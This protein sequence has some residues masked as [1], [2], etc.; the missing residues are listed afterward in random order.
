M[1]NR[2]QHAGKRVIDECLGTSRGRRACLT[3]VLRNPGKMPLTWD[4]FPV[5]CWCGD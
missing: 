4:L 2:R 1:R 3:Q 5:P